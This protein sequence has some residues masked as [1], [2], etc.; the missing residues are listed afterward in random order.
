MGS[1]AHTDYSCRRYYSQVVQPIVGSNE[2]GAS[3]GS[4]MEFILRSTV[5]PWC[6]VYFVH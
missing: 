2:R 5:L 4:I 6:M 3:A 1:M